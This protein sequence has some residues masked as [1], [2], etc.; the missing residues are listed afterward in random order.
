MLKVA[1]KGIMM[2]CSARTVE[3]GGGRT[4]EFKSIAPNN[5]KHYVPN[6]GIQ[7]CSALQWECVTKS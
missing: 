6:N 4:A 3:C 7:V 2:C 1:A 5:T